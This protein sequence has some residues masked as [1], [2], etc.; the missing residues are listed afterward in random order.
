MPRPLLG[1]AAAFAAGALLA[2]RWGVLPAPLLAALAA[3]L[4]TAAV[5][6]R[7]RQPAAASLALLAAFAV[8]GALRLLAVAHPPDPTHLA[9]LPPD[10]TPRRCR[11]AGRIVAPPEE[12]IPETPGTGVPDRLVL[13][14]EAERL[15]CGPEAVPATG[16]VRL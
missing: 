1:F 12:P 3:L 5:W 7:A 4:L 2:D 9:H 10:W 15:A 6:W 8:I 14:L 13:R 16:G 11:L